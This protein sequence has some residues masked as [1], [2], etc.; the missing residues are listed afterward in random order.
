MDLMRTEEGEEGGEEEGKG[1]EVNKNHIQEKI[2]WKQQTT[3]A[4]QQMKTST[5]KKANHHSN[6]FLNEMKEN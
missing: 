6:F 2:E 3:I 5:I 4:K 1:R